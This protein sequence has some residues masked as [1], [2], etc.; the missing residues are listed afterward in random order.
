MSRMAEMLSP[1]L[2]AG[3][4]IPEPL[5]RAWSW[6]E[7]QGWGLSNANGYFL[8]PYAGERQLGVVFSPGET[9]TGWF[10]PGEPG[11]DRLVPLAEI[12]GDGGIGAAWLGD[13][14]VWFAAL[15]SDG[16][17]FL[18]AESAVDFLRLIAIGHH[19]LNPWDLELEPQEPESVEAHAPFRAWVE[20]EFGVEVPDVWGKAEPDPFEA[21]VERVKGDVG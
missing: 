2:P 3:F 13:D 8:T 21:W 7:R 20:S 11:Y 15:G 5:E 18:L 14:E 9:L 4:V 6:M 16:D 19:D 12:S 17:T 10:E 1:K